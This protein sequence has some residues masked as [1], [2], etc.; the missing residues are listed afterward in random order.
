MACQKPGRLRFVRQPALFLDRDGTIN[1]DLIGNYVLH[2]DKLQLVPG[3]ATALSEA[4][5][6]G[7]KLGVVTNQACIG[8]GL[9]THE[10]LAK[11]HEH[12]EYLVRQ[13]ANLDRFHFD[14][15]RYCPH[16]A[17]E[18]CACRKPNTGMLEAAIA[19]LNPVLDRSFFIGDKPADLGCANNA[20]IRSILVLTGYGSGT[21]KEVEAG[22]CPTPYAVC[23]NLLEAVRWISEDLRTHQS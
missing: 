21:L 9:L 4:R 15:L 6:A 23:T 8:K 20:G 5:A 7:F 3:A 11:I 2:P 13:E 12:L 18:G 22:K 19:T 1:V 16:R 10:G 14:D 17:D